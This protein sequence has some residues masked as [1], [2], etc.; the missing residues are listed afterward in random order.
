MTN[1]KLFFKKNIIEVGVDEVARGCLAGRVYA[2]AVIWNPNFEEKTGI[3]IPDIKDSKKIKPQLRDEYSEFIKKYAD[4]Y[5]IGWVDE[6]EIDKINIRN[7]S[8]KAMHLALDNLKLKPTFILVDGNGFNKYKDIDHECIIKG[9]NTYLSIAMASIL[10]KTSRDNYIKQLVLENP[11]LN[12]Y[13][14]S[15]NNAYGTKKH[16]D[17]IKKY[18][19]TKYHRRTFGICKNYE[20]ISEDTISED[21][22]SEELKK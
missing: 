12:K 3:K 16:I 20:V 8:F 6:K 21:T 22:I 10:A 7:A 4:D 14:W 18:G 1:L 13:G 19:I 2:A 17:A 5:G 11:Y 15:E 9:D